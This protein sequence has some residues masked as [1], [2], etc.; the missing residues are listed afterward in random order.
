MSQPVV[1]QVQIS[2]VR[3]RFEDIRFGE[4]VDLVVRKIQR[5]YRRQVSNHICRARKERKGRKRMKGKNGNIEL[6][7]IIPV[8]SP[9]HIT[10]RVNALTSLNLVNVVMTY[11]QT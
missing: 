1:T 4:V 8:A 7:S 6:Q 9:V 11:V 5:S 10:A 2:Q 3:W